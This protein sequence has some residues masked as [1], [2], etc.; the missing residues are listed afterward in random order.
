MPEALSLG[1]TLGRESRIPAVP[2]FPAPP[3]AMAGP[4]AHEE[5]EEEE[6]CSWWNKEAGLIH[7]RCDPVCVLKVRV[8]HASLSCAKLP[9]V[10]GHRSLQEGLFLRLICCQGQMPKAGLGICVV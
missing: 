5:E 2:P 4:E 3:G 8:H 6:I 9:L 10:P 7:L 1:D